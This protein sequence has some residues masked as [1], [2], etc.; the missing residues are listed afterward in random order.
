MDDY[1][2]IPLHEDTIKDICFE[3]RFSILPLNLSLLPYIDLRAQ[4]IYNVHSL[5]NSPL[6]EKEFE[7]INIIGDGFRLNQREISRHANLSLGMTNLLLKRMVTKGYLRIRQLNRKKVEYLLTTQGFSEKLQKTY[8]YTLKTIES[9]GLIRSGIQRVLLSKLTKDIQQIVIVGEGDLADLATLILQEFGETHHAI[10]RAT[11]FPQNVDAQT[12][13]VN[14][15]L[16]ASQ[17]GA[18]QG[19]AN[20]HLL[21]SL[22]DTPRNLPKAERVAIR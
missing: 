18:A 22:A 20:I 2:R 17:A 8:H 14:A 10:T 12:L 7:I 15:S 16:N 13:V 19:I 11:V 6:S 21:Q 1:L 4:G 3:S 9:F 5:N